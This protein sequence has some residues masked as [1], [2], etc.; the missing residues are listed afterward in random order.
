[1][2]VIKMDTSRPIY[3]IF[4]LGYTILSIQVYA[5][6]ATSATDATV[7]QMHISM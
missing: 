6:D 4:T 2:I 1:M 3:S 7:Q 5:T